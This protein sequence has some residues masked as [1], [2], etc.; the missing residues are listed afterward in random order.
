MK[1]TL[2]LG[3]G[4]ILLRDE[5]IGVRVVEAMRTLN[6]AD[7]V[8]LLDGGTSGCDLVEV[9][10]DRPK[11][12]VID[13]ADLEG[14]PGTVCRFSGDDLIA[15]CE[16]TISLHEIGL[17]ETLLMTR[18]LGCPPGEVVIFGVKPADLSVGL[19]LSPALAKRVDD[20][21]RLVTDELAAAV[22]R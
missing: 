19:E 22:A 10:A 15:R 21:I 17:A 1:S 6:L 14:P 9:L 20:I 16:G 11:V 13:A 18:Q 2:I 4:N 7:E 12:I 8:E 3:I 5:G